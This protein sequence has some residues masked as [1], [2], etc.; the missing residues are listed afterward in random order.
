MTFGEKL[1]QLRKSRG[2]SQQ[3]LA[4]GLGVAQSSVAAYEAGTREPSFEVVQKFARYFRVPFSSLM[5]S[6][7]VVDG[8]FVQQLADALHKNPKLGLLF[9][10]ARYLK[11]ADI[12]AVLSVVNAIARER[13]NES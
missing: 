13:E 4:D 2:I 12:D 7:E 3:K 5:P 9:D 8:E 10:K 11:S 6:D 1:R